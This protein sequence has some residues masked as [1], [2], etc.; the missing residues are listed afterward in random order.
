MVCSRNQSV[1]QALVSVKK[2]GNLYSSN[3]NNNNN[4]NTMSLT[5]N[6]AISYLPHNINLLNILGTCHA[7]VLTT[8]VFCDKLSTKSCITVV[9]TH[10]QR[11]V[12]MVCS[13]ICSDFYLHIKLCM[14]AKNLFSSLTIIILQLQMFPNT[15]IYICNCFLLHNTVTSNACLSTHRYIC[16]VTG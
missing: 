13:Y 4:N 12:P 7:N 16:Y 8:V 15:N 2:F 5:P 3:N 10:W 14:A 11:Q 9:K 6:G 1:P